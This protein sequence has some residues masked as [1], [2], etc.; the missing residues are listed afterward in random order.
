MQWWAAHRGAMH[1]VWGG[2]VQIAQWDVRM[3]QWHSMYLV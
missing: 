3:A 2:Y 1:H